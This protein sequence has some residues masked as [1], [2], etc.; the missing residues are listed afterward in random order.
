MYQY[1]IALSFASEKESFVQEVAEYLKGEGWNVFFS[2]YNQ[3]EMLSENLK[4][5]LFQVYQNESFVKVL[6]ISEKYLTSEYTRLEA[7][8]SMESTKQERRRLIVVNYL[9]DKLP[10]EFKPLVYMDGKK[11]SDEIAY[12]VSERIKELK[13]CRT[14]KNKEQMNDV[15]INSGKSSEKTGIKIK[16]LNYINGN[17]SGIVAGGQVS[18]GEWRSENG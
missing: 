16:K 6:F 12:M 5:K 18:I 7:R 9:G 10:E 15:T 2:P 8:R 11:T 17:N 1:D 14:E 4:S 13:K 3:R